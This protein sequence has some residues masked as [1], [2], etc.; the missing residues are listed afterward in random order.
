MRLGLSSLF[1]FHGTTPANRPAE[2][3]CCVS[4]CWYEVR[5]GC[6]CDAVCRPVDDDAFR[7][8]FEWTNM[9]GTDA[10]ISKVDEDGSASSTTTNL[11]PF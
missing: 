6:D 8:R 9:S 2:G 5:A 1:A 4:R 11:R 7:M 3:W 10:F